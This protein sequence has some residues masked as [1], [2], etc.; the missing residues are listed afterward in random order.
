MLNYSKDYTRSK[1]ADKKKTKQR[2]KYLS[3]GKS[4]KNKKT[5]NPY[6]DYLN[7]GDSQYKMTFQQWKKRGF[8]RVINSELN[9]IKKTN[10]EKEE[11]SVSEYWSELT[12]KQKSK[13]RNK[14]KSNIVNKG[15]KKGSV[16]A[17]S[18]PMTPKR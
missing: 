10:A 12:V 8:N 5:K 3:I 18:Q 17:I 1:M 13:L 4:R 6:Q 14:A 2:K 15:R 16:W 7:D 9:R 11:I